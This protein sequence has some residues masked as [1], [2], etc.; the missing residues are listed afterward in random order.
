MAMSGTSNRY[1][2]FLVA[3]VVALIS[4]LAGLVV[5]AEPPAAL[6]D[7]VSHNTTLSPPSVD[8][9]THNITLGLYAEDKQDFHAAYFRWGRIIL[10]SQKEIEPHSHV[11][12]RKERFIMKNRFIRASF[13]SDFIIEFLHVRDDAAFVAGELRSDYFGSVHEEY[14]IDNLQWA[15]KRAVERQYYYETDK[16]RISFTLPLTP[17]LLSFQSDLVEAIK[18][19]LDSIAMRQGDVSKLSLFATDDSTGLFDE[20]IFKPKSLKPVKFDDDTSLLLIPESLQIRRARPMLSEVYSTEWRTKHFYLHGHQ[21]VFTVSFPK[22]RKYELPTHTIAI[23]L[24]QS[25]PLTQKFRQIQADTEAAEKVRLAECS[26]PKHQKEIRRGLEA[27]SEGK[28]EE[29]NLLTLMH[30]KP[31][32]LVHPDTDISGEGPFGPH[33]KFFGTVAEKRFLAK[34][35]KAVQ[36]SMTDFFKSLNNT[37]TV[38]F[39]DLKTSENNFA[40]EDNIYAYYAGVD[41]LSKELLEDLFVH[42]GNE[43]E[44]EGIRIYGRGEAL[45][46]WSSQ[47]GNP[48]PLKYYGPPQFGSSPQFQAT[49]FCDYHSY[50][51]AP[52][53]KPC[54]PVSACSIANHYECL[55]GFETV[56]EH[57]GDEEI[58]RETIRGITIKRWVP[59]SLYDTKTVLDRFGSGKIDTVPTGVHDNADNDILIDL[60]YF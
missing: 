7:V 9:F 18:A 28:I 14:F 45:N 48:D 29:P 10:A 52:G 59:L 20:D 57:Y 12:M 36:A 13:G 11:R 46:T 55:S 42:L 49:L 32:R 51:P 5:V 4:V 21:A 37:R 60:P 24:D 15:A 53:R 56:Q 27:L 23:A 47:H 38:V 43:L 30:I 26:C 58:G 40:S 34:V 22:T 16:P 8:F 31:A 25:L 33:G 6:S 50:L 3:G 1:N 19:E 39:K 2:L 17:T 41:S 35:S 54:Q 44:L